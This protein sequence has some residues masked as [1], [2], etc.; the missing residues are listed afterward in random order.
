MI[1]VELVGRTEDGVWKEGA[2]AIH[3]QRPQ[4]IRAARPVVLLFGVLILLVLFVAL[5][6]AVPP[7][8]KDALVHHLA[9]P[10][11]YLRHGGMV[12]LP[13]MPFSYYPMNLNILYGAALYL[14]N[15]ILP[16]Y[17]HFAFALATALCLFLYL[18]RR[19]S[20]PYGA[21]GALFFLSIPIIIQL[22]ITVYIDLGVICFITCAILFLLK[23]VETGMRFRWLLLSALFCGLAMGT[24]YNALIALFLLTLSVPF[25]YSR[26]APAVRGRSVRALGFCFAYFLIAVLV[27]SPWFV[28]NY[29]WTGNPLYPLYNQWFQAHKTGGEGQE[30]QGLRQ[31][32]TTGAAPKKAGRG[33]FTYRSWAY[34]ESGLEIALLPL[35]IFF[36]GKDGDHRYFD[37]RLHPLLLLLPLFAF[38]RS[39][40]GPPGVRLE[41]AFLLAF[42]VLF[43]AF[44][45]FSEVMRVRYIAPMIP[46]LVILAAFGMKNLITW[47]RSLE[48]R[49]ARRAGFLVVGAA[50]V[51]GAAYSA[52]YLLEQ[53]RIVQPLTYLKGDVSREEYITARRPEYPVAQWA[54]RGIPTDAK[55]LLVFMGKRGYYLDRDY[56]VG[57]ARL[58]KLIMKA[59]TPEGIADE[60]EKDAITHLMVFLPLLDKWAGDNFD[61]DKIHTMNRFFKE[62]A[63][64]LCFHRGYGLFGVK[65][66]R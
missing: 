26:R 61:E 28:R 36:Q 48:G 3:T 53:Y 34:G 7:V 33:M 50:M 44:A 55:V 8:S 59:G 4:R 14:G 56:I 32:L 39:R 15:D 27:C 6:A 20:A 66:V 37:G 10:K 22:S 31:A 30:G 5:L 2:V 12:E 49:R 63:T 16:K 62:Y 41:K 24:K 21:F 45:L 58:G 43:F 17:I 65:R 1:G 47:I 46:P 11:I 64:L 29:Q 60:L 25:F 13:S 51:A 52:E 40:E 57:E 35:R 23:W 18:K 9:V 42:A 19:L 38:L 54:N